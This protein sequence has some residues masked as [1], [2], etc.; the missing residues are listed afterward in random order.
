MA[1][2]GHKTPQ[3]ARL[4]VKRTETQRVT[5]AR[6]RRADIQTLIDGAIDGAYRAAALTKRLLA[7]SRQQPQEPKPVSA[8]KLVSG[9]SDMIRRT[10]GETIKTETVL[11]GGLWTTH[12]DPSE[13]ENA[14]LNLC[15][16]A[17]HAGAGIGYGY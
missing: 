12:A 1:L 3:A 13:L 10:L 2:S 11:A 17:R 6:K 15:V 16:N 7:F 5:A 4:Y 8:N 14:L 9:M